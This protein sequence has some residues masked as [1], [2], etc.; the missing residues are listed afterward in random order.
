[1]SIK[2]KI[3]ILEA[4]REAGYTSYKLRTDKLMSE[5]TIQKLRNGEMVAMSNIDI[6]CR[7]LS[8]QPGDLIEY[9]SAE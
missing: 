9:I 6:V 2:Y 8:C 1:M 4:L 7:L 5:S 3:D